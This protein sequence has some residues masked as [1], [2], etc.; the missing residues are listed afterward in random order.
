MVT[1]FVHTEQ[2]CHEHDERENLS[3][4]THMWKIHAPRNNNSD[5]LQMALSQKNIKIED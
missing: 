3:S 1:Q 5:E 4:L 2:L